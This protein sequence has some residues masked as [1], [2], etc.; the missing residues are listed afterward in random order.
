[1]STQKPFE[2]YLSPPHMEGNELKYLNEAFE[3]N[4]I[5]S[6]GP[7]L[8]R[9][10]KEFA[11]YVGAEAACAVSSGTAAL[12]LALRISGV[13]KGDIVL[14]PSFTFIATVTAALELGAKIEFIDS[15]TESWNLDPE[16]LEQ[17]IDELA[18][19]GKKPKAILPVHL[20]GVSADMHAIRR[21]C[22]THSIDIIEDAAESLGARIGSDHTGGFGRFGVYSFN[23]NKIITTSGGG[24]LT[25]NSEDIRQAK[26]LSTQARDPAPHYEHTTTGYNFRMSNLLAA[27]GIGQLELI[28]KKVKKRRQIHE[29]YTNLLN[30]EIGIS[31]LQEPKGRY[32]NWWLTSII[33]DPS[34]GQSRDDI[35]LKLTEARI[36]ARPLWKPLHL[37]PVF[38]SFHITGGAICD[39]LFKNG[40]CLPSGSALS[41]EDVERISK[42]IR[43]PS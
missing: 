4:W 39:A 37:Q 12:H 31:V 19:E 43:N 41:A 24:M 25:G 27:V 30:Q 23:G 18:A 8:D 15:E 22:Q 5:S 38:R 16:L 28:D 17:R 42:I 34:C 32:A 20:Y 14:A 7:H 10:E 33:V 11:A 9:F 36:E 26:F 40:L 29:W 2:I 1:M 35:L 3:S 21:I 13:G 6:V